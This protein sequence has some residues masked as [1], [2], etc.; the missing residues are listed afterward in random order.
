MNVKSYLN[1]AEQWMP[2][3]IES[4]QEYHEA[5]SVLKKLAETSQ[6]N[7]DDAMRMYQDLVE[8]L[9]AK[10]RATKLA[11]LAHNHV[12][13]SRVITILRQFQPMQDQELF[14]HTGI[15]PNRWNEV[16]NG[17]PLERNEIAILCHVFKVEPHL[18]SYSLKHE[19]VHGTLLK[20]V[21]SALPQPQ[22]V[23]LKTKTKRPLP[24]EYLTIYW[25]EHDGGT[26]ELKRTAPAWKHRIHE[27]IAAHEDD[28]MREVFPDL[29]AQER[30][31]D[32]D[33]KE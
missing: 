17:H 29:L 28:L 25:E 31:D 9:V 26:L 5:V 11:E 1:C 15:S 23:H 2:R 7:L 30:K 10:Y 8:D 14:E 21:E 6:Q 32:P 13:D 3:L 12:P 33:T 19:Y 24:P 22:L 16:L 20:L 18:F 27:Y 4:M